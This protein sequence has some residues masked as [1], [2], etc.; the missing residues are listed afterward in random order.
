M[1]NDAPGSAMISQPGANG[2]GAFDAQR[3]WA[4]PR[5]IESPAA[6]FRRAKFER[7]T[8]GMLDRVEAAPRPQC[9]IRRGQ[10]NA[11]LPLASTFGCAATPT[12]LCRSSA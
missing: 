2:F 11:F 12:R 5:V 8:A 10:V 1:T 4:T 9:N 6:V 3:R 7:L